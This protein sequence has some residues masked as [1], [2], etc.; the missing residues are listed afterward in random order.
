MSLTETLTASHENTQSI[1]LESQSRL[2][3][4]PSLLGLG[5]EELVDIALTRF[6][7]A[8]IQ[9]VE[10]G[11]LLFRRMRVPIVIKAC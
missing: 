6:Q 8:S 10:W 1:H 2:S 7:C 3:L 4:S 11:A 9:V 5:Q